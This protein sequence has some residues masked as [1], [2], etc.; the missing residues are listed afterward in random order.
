ME[1][2]G[3]RVFALSEE[4]RGRATGRPHPRP[5]PW[6]RVLLLLP[7]GEG[8]DQG[9]EAPCCPPKGRRPTERWG[10]RSPR[11]SQ[12]YGILH[13][14]NAFAVP[15]SIDPAFGIHRAS[16]ESL[17]PWK[18]RGVG[19]D[20][21]ERGDFLGG[22]LDLGGAEVVLQLGERAR[23]DDG[24]GDERLGQNPGDRDLADAAATLACD[25]V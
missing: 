24:T 12:F 10:R 16:A 19:R 5:I 11:K 8:W 23:P 4:I 22:E 18:R 9:G 2:T 7:L 15:I 6:E 17:V 20:R 3:A 1:R 14:L 13:A 21:V 25:L